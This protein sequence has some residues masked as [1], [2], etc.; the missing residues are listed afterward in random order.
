[1]FERQ[2]VMLPQ[3]KDLFV[4]INISLF[5]LI[6]IDHA[7]SVRLSVS[8]IFRKIIVSLNFQHLTT[9]ECKGENF[10][11]F[12]LTKKR[13]SRQDYKFSVDCILR[14]MMTV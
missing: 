4:L 2:K 11:R 12:G 5:V 9:Y 8:I 14:D 10:Q 3:Q 1:M 6:K 7:T 13:L